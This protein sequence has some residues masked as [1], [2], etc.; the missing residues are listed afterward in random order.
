M[1]QKDRLSMHSDG[2][3]RSEFRKGRRLLNVVARLVAWSIVS[4][5]FAS[6]WM[7]TH[8]AEAQKNPAA[9]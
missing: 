1:K 5:F 7:V 3:L 8:A 4:F 2:K 6:S 9:N